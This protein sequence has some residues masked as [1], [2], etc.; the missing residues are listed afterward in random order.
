MA[1]FPSKCQS[2]F[3]TGI[4]QSQRDIPVKI[5]HLRSQKVNLFIASK[6]L[7]FPTLQFENWV[8]EDSKW[9]SEPVAGPLSPGWSPWVEFVCSGA[10]QTPVPA[11]AALLLLH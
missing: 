5:K 10:V 3:T 6:Q 8:S 4:Q 1:S 2:L 7:P 9:R 11:P